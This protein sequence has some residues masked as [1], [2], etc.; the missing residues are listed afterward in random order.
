MCSLLV[1]LIEILLEHT[2]KSPETSALS[3]VY[4]L[5]NVHVVHAW[6][7]GSVSSDDNSEMH[8]EILVQTGKD[9]A[10]NN[11]SLYMSKQIASMERRQRIRKPT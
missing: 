8:S 2:R 6:H 11:S 10:S 7:K 1:T 3:C 4:C 5:C 9:V